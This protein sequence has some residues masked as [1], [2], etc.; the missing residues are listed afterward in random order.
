MQHR[1]KTWRAIFDAMWVGLKTF[2]FR[3]NDRDF[4]TGDTLL[5][6]EWNE[7]EEIYT[8]RTI[9]AV[10]TYTLSGP[11]FGIPEGYCIMAISIYDRTDNA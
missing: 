6:Q 9:R 10:V 2:E 4:S 1:L 8:C 7:V 5:L 3:R 11:A